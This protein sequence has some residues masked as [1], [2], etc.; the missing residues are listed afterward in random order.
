MAFSPDG[1]RLVTG[2]SEG[3]C[4]LFDVPG[5]GVI[6]ALPRHR[7]RVL[8]AA[9]APNG[10]VVATGG[11]DNLIRLW[12]VSA[13]SEIALFAGHRDAVT[14]LAF[15]A[16]GETLASGGN[17][18]MVRLW[19]CRTRRELGA[20]E[21]GREITFVSFTPRGDWLLIGEGHRGPLHLWRTGR[22]D[23]ERSP[24]ESTR[25]ALSDRWAQLMQTSRTNLAAHR[26]LPVAPTRDARLRPQLVDLSAHFNAGLVETW[27]VSD[28]ANHFLALSPGVRRFGG[29]EFDVRGVVVLAGGEDSRRPARAGDIRVGATCR[30]IHFLHAA[31]LVNLDYQTAELPTGTEVA[32]YVLH[33]QDGTRAEMPVRMGHEVSNWHVLPTVA[34]ASAPQAPRVVWT[35][36]NP[37]SRAN[38]R[39]TALFLS[40]WENPRP[41]VPVERIDFVSAGTKAEPFLLGITVE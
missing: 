8:G 29:V 12:D 15:S 3:T 27:A 40:T 35:S 30:S 16:D 5:R 7:G 13:R 14:C 26:R 6:A 41:N 1:S 24:T 11:A 22:S 34:E 4:Q 38:G 36:A 19:H 32:R 37:I 39:L 28:H 17:D 33:W 20:F 23:G 10:R 21:F 25:T 9:F 18:R 31:N 2:T